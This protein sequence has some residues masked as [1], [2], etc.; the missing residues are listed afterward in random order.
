MEI[1]LPFLPSADNQL[2][3]HLEESSFQMIDVSAKAATLRTAFAQGT[4]HLS[5]SAFEALVNGTNPKG[6][7]L[8][9]AEVT[10]IMGAKKT[11]SLLP[12]CHPL[13]IEKIKI[14]FTKDFENNSVTVFSEV[15]T[16][17][18][19]GV[20]MEALTAVNAALL[21]IYDL[22]KAVDPVIE[23]SNVRLNRKVGGKS[24]DWKHPRFSEAQA[25]AATESHHSSLDGVKV[26]ILVLSDR[27]AKEPSLDKSGPTAE[28][29]FTARGAKVIERKILTDDIS[30]IRET[31]EELTNKNNLGLLILSGGTGVSPRDVTPEALLPLWTKQIP[32]IGEFLRASG[33][34]HH[35]MAY[36]SRGEGGLIKNT[37]VICLPGSEKAVSEGLNALEHMLPHLLHVKS[38]GQH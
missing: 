12:L 25:T 6:D 30:V 4:I 29:F 33:A 8:A 37:L 28:N 36:L 3:S 38:G 14:H 13:P 10:G 1:I 22:S 21:G 24:G 31:V 18:K 15:T 17:G 32:G 19:T 2:S 23:I 34:K 7:V 9:L 35:E 5:P 26:S 27:C 20:E 16:T 11:A